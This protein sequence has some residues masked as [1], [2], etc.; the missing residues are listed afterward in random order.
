MSFTCIRDSVLSCSAL[1]A[2]IVTFLDPLDVIAYLTVSKAVGQFF[3]GLIPQNWKRVSLNNNPPPLPHN[4]T[5]NS[6]LGDIAFGKAFLPVPTL[7]LTQGE[8]QTKMVQGWIDGYQGALTIGERAA[9]AS[10]LGYLLF[11]HPKPSGGLSL[12]LFELLIDQDQSDLLLKVLPDFSDKLAEENKLEHLKKGLLYK[13]FKDRAEQLLQFA[14]DREKLQMSWKELEEEGRFSEIK[15][16][17][18]KLDRLYRECS[19]L[20]EKSAALK[21]ENAR[22][23]KRSIYFAIHKQNRQ[24]F[25]RLQQFWAALL[26]PIASKYTCEADGFLILFVNENGRFQVPSIQDIVALRS[27][28]QRL[29]QQHGQMPESIEGQNQMV[30]AQN[31]LRDAENMRTSYQA[32]VDELVPRQLWA[33]SARAAGK[34]IEPFK[35]LLALWR[36]QPK[37]F[38]QEKAILLNP[39]ALKNRTQSID[40]L[41][42]TATGEQIAEC[43]E[44]NPWLIRKAIENGRLFDCVK[45]ISE[46]GLLAII[47]EFPRLIGKISAKVIAQNMTGGVVLDDLRKLLRLTYP[48]LGPLIKLCCDQLILTA[49]IKRDKEVCEQI[50]NFYIDNGFVPSIEALMKFYSADWFL[51]DPWLSGT[52]STQFIDQALG[53]VDATNRRDRSLVIGAYIRLKP[54]LSE[55]DCIKI[56][57]AGCF[58]QHPFIESMLT[59][60]HSKQVRGL[61]LLHWQGIPSAE[62]APH[63]FDMSNE[64]RKTFTNGLEV[65]EEHLEAALL[66]TANEEEDLNRWFVYTT[67]PEYTECQRYA[68]A[69][70]GLKYFMTQR[71]WALLSSPQV[72]GAMVGK[73]LLLLTNC[74]KEKALFELVESIGEY[75][76][77]RKLEI[78]LEDFLNILKKYPHD[79]YGNRSVEIVAH[80]V[81]FLTNLE[82]AVNY[83]ELALLQGLA[84]LDGRGGISVVK[85]LIQSIIARKAPLSVLAIT[86]ILRNKLSLPLTAEAGCLLREQSEETVEAIFEES[87]E[88][89][90]LFE[91]LWSAYNGKKALPISAS[92]LSRLF[93]AA[94]LKQPRLAAEILEVFDVATLSQ[95][96]IEDFINAIPQVEEQHLANLLKKVKLEGE[97]EIKANSHANAVYRTAIDIDR[98]W[99]FEQAS[100]R[101]HEGFMRFIL[102][103][104][105]KIKEY[106]ADWGTLSAFQILCYWFCK[107]LS[108][109]VVNIASLIYWIQNHISSDSPNLAMGPPLNVSPVM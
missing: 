76:K 77:S 28:E 41:F 27:E 103:I 44:E 56:L 67:P 96:Q 58:L 79:G 38:E 98:Q 109:L 5:I 68:G 34:D 75:V 10:W 82:P 93:S 106:E 8:F 55:A 59:A 17:R 95:A 108:A 46:Q 87:A 63:I 6:L 9:L 16:L 105:Q 29:R 11:E 21:E 54:N 4:F 24:L 90:V 102:K 13:P 35:E 32:A 31:L 37:T 36:Q 64:I 104:E 23:V 2:H 49:D 12:Q 100:I 65:P 78:P 107:A 30:V 43:V 52:W 60:D 50:A 47:P 18:E 42:K 20:N 39:I 86:A 97:L 84:W 88:D 57:S 101:K 74:V 3:L 33:L 53:A 99:F 1:Q 85:A 48:L 83:F 25:E 15:N 89:M 61:A 92:L 40:L 62:G 51:S 19:I 91:K 81:N 70:H 26:T 69:E 14:N 80:L 72:T 45:A 66:Q 73:L 7:L 71:M 22:L 94:L